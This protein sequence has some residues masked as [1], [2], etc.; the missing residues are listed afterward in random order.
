MCWQGPQL[1][2]PLPPSISPPSPLHT[3]EAPQQ[4]GPHSNTTCL[5]VVLLS[6]VLF[7]YSTWLHPNH[8]KLL[9]L[10]SDPIVPVSYELNNPRLHPNLLQQ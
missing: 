7:Y 9:A 5:L 1:Y 6:Q 3:T 2:D 10:A 8:S 4:I